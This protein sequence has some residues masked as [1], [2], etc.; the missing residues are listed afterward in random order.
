M[1]DISVAKGGVSLVTT[2]GAE[3][4]SEHCWDEI[5]S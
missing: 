3:G 4:T 1:G 5:V 2:N